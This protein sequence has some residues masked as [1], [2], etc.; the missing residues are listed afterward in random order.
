MYVNKWTWLGFG[1]FL[2]NH[3]VL[4]NVQPVELDTRLVGYS[5]KP[6]GLLN[7]PKSASADRC[8]HQL[9]CWVT[10]HPFPALA[11]APTR[12]PQRGYTVLTPSLDGIPAV[13]Q[14]SL[15][16][17]YS[18]PGSASQHDAGAWRISAGGDA[19]SV[20]SG[21]AAQASSSLSLTLL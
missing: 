3:T 10:R 2:N 15:S 4:V 21:V 13:V 12:Q 17:P 16:Q 5:H 7:L 18:T 14:T 11:Y 1:G 9:N 20:I 8:H 6:A 19:A